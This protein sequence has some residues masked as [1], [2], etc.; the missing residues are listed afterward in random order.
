MTG[1]AALGGKAAHAFADGADVERIGG[2]GQVLAVQF[3]AA[4]RDED[5]IVLLAVGFHLPAGGGLDV[6]TG[7]APFHRRGDAI[8]GQDGIDLFVAGFPDFLFHAPN[9]IVFEEQVG[10]VG[11][12]KSLRNG[13]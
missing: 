13:C 6:R 5:D 8:V 3:G 7:F 11:G 9:S 4:D 2:A 10:L 12:E 1:C